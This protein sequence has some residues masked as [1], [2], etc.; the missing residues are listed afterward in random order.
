MPFVPEGHSRIFIALPLNSEVK[1]MIGSLAARLRARFDDAR[2]VP[3]DNYHLTLHFIGEVPS[4]A[5]SEIW[6]I[7]EPYP[8]RF[9]TAKIAFDKIGFFGKP[10]FP[11]VLFLHANALKEDLE[12]LTALTSELRNSLSEWGKP[13]DKPFSPHLTLARF[14]KLRPGDAPSARNEKNLSSIDKFQRGEQTAKYDWLKFAPIEAIINRVVLYE[15]VFEK[16][17]VEYHEIC[18]WNLKTKPPN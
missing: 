6:Q 11:R 10:R 16:T 5:L 12:S 17:G 2:W 3:T 15:S 14:N 9:D 18:E 7:I 4:T 13:D 1:A 8:R